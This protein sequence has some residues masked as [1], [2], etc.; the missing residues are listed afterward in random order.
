VTYFHRQVR[1][2]MSD[3]YT[4]IRT[5]VTVLCVSAD[6]INIYMDFILCT[7]Y[8]YAL[9]EGYNNQRL[10]PW[11]AFKKLV[12]I[13]E[14]KSVDCEEGIK[15]L[16]IIYLTHNL[17]KITCYYTSSNSV[18]RSQFSTKCIIDLQFFFTS[19]IHWMLTVSE[20]AF[21]SLE[22]RKQNSRHS[23]VTFIYWFYCMN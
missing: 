9:N 11:T 3:H 5:Y 16:N 15:S 20:E 12:V 4:Y 10:F 19:E 18:C 2:V 21:T 7:Q 17:Q 8:V 14:T 22:I 23:Y 13:T 6:N 1:R